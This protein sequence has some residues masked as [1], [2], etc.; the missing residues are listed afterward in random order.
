MGIKG[1]FMKKEDIK[2][3]IFAVLLILF[4]SVVFFGC[5]LSPIKH[6]V[7]SSNFDDNLPFVPFFACFY[8]LWY[9]YLLL[10]PFIL[11]RLN[12]KSFF[13]YSS[14]T[15]ICVIMGAIVFVLFPT[16]I[17]REVNINEYHSIFAY[18]VRFIYFTD[19][20]NLC[21]L[22][23]MHCALSFIF[24]Y[25]SLK[26]KEMKWYYKVLITLT[27]LGIVASTLFI[28]QHVIWDVFAAIV[29]VT[30]C[31]LID[32]YT[33]IGNYIGKRFNYVSKIISEKIFKTKLG[34]KIND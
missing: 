23:S 22:P 27:S 12:K 20:P 3:L 25:T 33:N 14:L 6:T 9:I 28:K 31:I 7:L 21:C 26:T 29:V 32:K 8:Y 5:K 15:I 4:E 17:N 10:I 24:I 18:L 11:N 2:V 34:N 16:T 19:T 13:R 1:D 30:I